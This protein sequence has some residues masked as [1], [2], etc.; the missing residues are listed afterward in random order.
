MQRGQ[1]DL[2]GCK[3]GDILISV[4][5]GILEYVGPL[6]EEHHYDHEVNYLYTPKD[7]VYSGK[8]KG[9]RCNDGYTYR[10]NRM[11]TDHDIIAIIPKELLPSEGI[12]EVTK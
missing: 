8:P 7:G 9:T 4:H 6:P 3:P 1:V 12:L 10:K 11:E 2:S 5:G